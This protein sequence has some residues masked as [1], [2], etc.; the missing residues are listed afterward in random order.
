MAD[1]E[2]F[3]TNAAR[4]CNRADLDAAI[5]ARARTQTKQHWLERLEAADVPCG[6]INKLE[7]VFAEP[8][9]A[10]REMVVTMPHPTAGEVKLVGNPIKGWA[11]LMIMV[12]VLGG[13]QM[14]TLGVFGEYLWRILVQVQRRNP[15]L[16]EQI[17][18]A[19]ASPAR[20][21]A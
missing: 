2:R 11:P 18:N 17:V 15:Y 20:P 9:I 21:E 10:A 16:V 13:A 4:V 6:P 12:L 7:E 1:D 14:L 19:P 8:Q 3:A 5:E